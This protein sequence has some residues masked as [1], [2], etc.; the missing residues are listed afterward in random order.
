MSDPKDR[1]SYVHDTEP[2]GFPAVPAEVVERFRRDSSHPEAIDARTVR[3]AMLDAALG[4]S[5][6]ETCPTCGGLGEVSEEKAREL[7]G[8]ARTSILPPPLPP[9]EEQRTDEDFGTVFL[10]V[11][12][13]R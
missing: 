13:E 1:P 4:P 10:D 6:R 2:G 7:R 8:Y 3:R 5:E 12:P 9:D 11:E